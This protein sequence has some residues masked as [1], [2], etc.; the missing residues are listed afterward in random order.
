MCGT[1]LRT[2]RAIRQFALMRIRQFPLNEDSGERWRAAIA[3]ACQGSSMLGIHFSGCE[4]VRSVGSRI[5]SPLS[6]AS[7]VHF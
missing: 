4:R 7:P 2:G 1:A 3:E 6:V 5:P